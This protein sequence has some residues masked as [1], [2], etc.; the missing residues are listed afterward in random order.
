M[1][2][3]REDIEATAVRDDNCV[4]AVVGDCSG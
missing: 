2:G 1:G 3:L 4:G